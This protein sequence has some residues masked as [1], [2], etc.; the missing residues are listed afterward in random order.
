MPAE[1]EELF[2]YFAQDEPKPEPFSARAYISGNLAHQLEEEEEEQVIQPAARPGKAEQ[3]HKEV[4]LWKRAVILAFV[5]V[6]AAGL[7]QVAMTYSELYTAKQERASMQAKLEET[8]QTTAVIADQTS[9]DLTLSDLYAYATG[10]L[11]MKEASGGE[12]TEVDALD[13]GYTEQAVQ[14]AQRRPAQVNFHLFGGND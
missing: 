9:Q 14:E 4:P 3:T 6:L 2:D 8:K 11:G 1:A 12:I 7:L 5:L 13:T 10:H